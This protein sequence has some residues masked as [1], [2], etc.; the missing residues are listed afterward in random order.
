MH[1]RRWFFLQTNFVAIRRRDNGTPIV[2]LSLNLSRLI[3]QATGVF[4]YPFLPPRQ[5]W[6]QFETLKLI[7]DAEFNILKSYL[8]KQPQSNVFNCLSGFV[9]HDS[10][11]ESK[12]RKLNSQAICLPRLAKLNSIEIEWRLQRLNLKA[13]TC[14][15]NYYKTE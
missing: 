8:L 12:D 2:S 4:F 11:A 1:K 10:P 7:N 5:Q 6:N 9:A 15:S 3:S 14:D 13:I